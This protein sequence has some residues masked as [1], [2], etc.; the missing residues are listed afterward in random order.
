MTVSKYNLDK[1][2]KLILNLHKP[3]KT[4]NT[5]LLILSGLPG[6]G[7]SYLADLIA[8][9]LPVTVIETDFIRKH[10]FKQPTYSWKE[11]SS[12][13]SLCHS[14]IEELLTNKI[15]VLVD[16]TN[17]L[18]QNR[19]K[20]Y[21]IAKT[22]KSEILLIALTAPENIVIERLNQRTS[23]QNLNN[24][25]ADVDVYKKLKRTAQPILRK[26]YCI[27]SSS[28]VKPQLQKLLQKA[29]ILLADKKTNTY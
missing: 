4:N 22:N 15:S 7:K 6:T 17:L 21:Q 10:L 2:K 29:N 9:N 26:H 13:F 28:A 11:N 25:S 12:V 3:S 5:I 18:R 16:A 19:K 1:I 8:T 23:N 24:S 14:L 20:L 27:D